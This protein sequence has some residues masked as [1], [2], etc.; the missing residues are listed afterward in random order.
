MAGVLDHI[1][2]DYRVSDPLT[3]SYTTAVRSRKRL[4]YPFLV[5]KTA[6]S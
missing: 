5:I 2:G 1:R 4:R 6:P 3:N